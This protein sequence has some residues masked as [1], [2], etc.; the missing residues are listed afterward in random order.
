MQLII[1]EYKIDKSITKEEVSKLISEIRTVSNQNKEEI[2]KELSNT[3]HDLELELKKSILTIVKGY[4]NNDKINVDWDYLNEQ[5]IEYYV[6]IEENKI[7]P[8]QILQLNE[9]Y[10]NKIYLDN[11][12]LVNSFGH[13]FDEIK[14]EQVLQIAADITNIDSN[15]QD[16]I[17]MVEIKDYSNTIVQ[18]AKWVS[19]MLNSNQTLN[20]GLSWIPKETGKYTAIISTGTGMDSVLQMTEI[21]I[22]VN[23]EGNISDVNY[24]KNGYELLFK[25][26]D[27][28]PICATPNT[29]SKLTNIGLAFA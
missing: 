9:N 28:S 25:Y 19:G 21:E 26:A 6:V 22:N 14:S 10:R 13:A 27:N 4:E 11:F 7:E 23:P 18:P 29:A 5:F 16:F 15:Q 20:V 17:Y 24:C 12:G 3:I 2:N 8:V 1:K